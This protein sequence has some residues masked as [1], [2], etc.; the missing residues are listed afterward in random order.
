MERFVLNG[1]RPS[2]SAATKTFFFT[3]LMKLFFFNEAYFL[4]F[5]RNFFWQTW[6]FLR[7]D[8]F[9][10][11]F[12]SILFVLAKLYLANFIWWNFIWRTSF[13]KTSFGVDWQRQ[14]IPWLCQVW[15]WPLASQWFWFF[16]KLLDRQTD[17]CSIILYRLYDHRG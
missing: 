14:S 9:F 12:F 2:W 16:F 1:Q 15:H 4:H 13:G 7:F 5:W 17:T 11:T 6:F 10:F 8:D 3:F